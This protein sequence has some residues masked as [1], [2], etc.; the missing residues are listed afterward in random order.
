MQGD[1]VGEL[2]RNEEM[3]GFEKDAGARRPGRFS[4]QIYSVIVHE[5]ESRGMAA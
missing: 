5:S 4:K 1:L 3:E 2:R